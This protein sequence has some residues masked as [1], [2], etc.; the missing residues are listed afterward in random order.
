M[1]APWPEPVRRVADFL[2]DAGSEA[3]LE[4]FRSGTPTAADAARAIGCDLRQI[5]KSLVV[6]CDGRGP[7]LVLVP[8]D[9]RADLRKIARA[10]R[11]PQVRVA[12][13]D[14]VEAAT[15]FRPGAVAPF[16]LP[17][18]ERV[19]IERTLLARD[20]VWIG[21]GSPRHMATLPALEL[22]RLT[23]AEPVDAVEEAA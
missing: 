2:R 8:G 7:L 12:G 21:A 4:E 19:F 13:A 18:I 5:V 10:A 1:S 22:A 3:R 9:A 6:E 14:R 16:P 11:C 17:Q 23:R 15:G 20:R